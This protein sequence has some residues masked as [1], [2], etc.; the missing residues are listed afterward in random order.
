MFTHIFK[1][2]NGRCPKCSQL[3]L[4]ASRFKI[5]DTCRNCGLVFQDNNDGTWFFLLMIDRALFIF[6]LVVLMYL[7]TNPILI[8]FIGVILIFLLI[9]ATPVRMG[10]SVAIDYYLKTKLSK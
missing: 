9:A 2:I 7:G 3:T 4:F 10:I 1:A 6:P 5:N 8:I